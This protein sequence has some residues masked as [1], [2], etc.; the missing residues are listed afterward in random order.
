M[1]LRVFDLHDL[2]VVNGDLHDAE[3]HRG[4]FLRDKREPSGGGARVGGGWIAWRG[5]SPAE[6]RCQMIAHV[7]CF[8][9][10]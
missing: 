10:Y 3:V 4:D 1:T 2:R 7:F 5:V 6:W 9:L 8:K